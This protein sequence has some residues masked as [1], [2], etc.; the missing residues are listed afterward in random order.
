MMQLRSVD[1]V[2]ARGLFLPDGEIRCVTCH[3]G[4]SRWRYGLAIPAGAVPQPAVNPRDP[5][6]HADPAAK[7][8][9]EAE[10]RAAQQSGAYGVKVSPKP[11]CLICHAI[12]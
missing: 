7:A 11:L 5:A 1:D 4:R 10:V 3:D 2:V 6:T 9:R 12:D 8:K